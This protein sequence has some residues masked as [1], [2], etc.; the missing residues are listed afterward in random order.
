MVIAVDRSIDEKSLTGIPL[1]L[2]QDDQVNLGLLPN[3][4]SEFGSGVPAA[5]NGKSLVRR[6]GERIAPAKSPAYLLVSIPNSTQGGGVIDVIDLATK[7]RIDTNRFVPAC[8]RFPRRRERPGRLLETVIV[9]GSPRLPHRG[10]K[11]RRDS[12]GTRR[13]ASFG[14]RGDGMR[15]S[16]A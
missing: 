6:V 1:D 11:A 15:G 13:A 4:A 16:A 3:H 12:I 9:S 10:S 7:R 8:S 14:P 2:A 5:V